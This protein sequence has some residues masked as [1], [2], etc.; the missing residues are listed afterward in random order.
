MLDHISDNPSRLRNLNFWDGP[1]FEWF[2]YSFKFFIR[3]TSSRKRRTIDLAV[4]AMKSTCLK[5]EIRNDF[6]IIWKF[7]GLSR[8]GT[9]EGLETLC[10][11]S[12]TFIDYLTGNERR[13]I[14][15]YIWEIIQEAAS[16]NAAISFTTD[17]SLITLKSVIVIGGTIITAIAKKLLK[18][19]ASI[20]KHEGYCRLQVCYDNLKRVSFVLVD[21]E[22]GAHWFV[23]VWLLFY[24]HV[25]VTKGSTEGFV[26]V[27]YFDVISSVEEVDK[28]FDCSCLMWET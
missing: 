24:L 3:T 27:Q 18:R 1:A 28:I 21:I 7:T 25:L 14:Q 6:L 19:G 15:N 26:V 8:D 2:N 5:R 4:N 13:A 12:C 17:L 16:S 20:A 22:K 23:R 9:K 10:D 11:I